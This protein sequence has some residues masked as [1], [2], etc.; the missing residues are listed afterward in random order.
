MFCHV[1]YHT[2]WSMTGL[3]G[4]A[5]SAVLWLA[6]RS[7]QQRPQAVAHEL[8]AGLPLIGV[9]WLVYFSQVRGTGL[10]VEG[11]AQAWPVLTGAAAL[12]A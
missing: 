6:T 12:L 9:P 5:L 10:G 1:L 4:I 3:T 7:D 11:M 2:P 8:A